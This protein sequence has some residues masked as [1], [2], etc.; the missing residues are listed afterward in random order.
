MNGISIKQFNAY[1][2]ARKFTE[3][4]MKDMEYMQEQI[5]IIIEND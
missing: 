1:K 4:E 3:D 2:K 5:D